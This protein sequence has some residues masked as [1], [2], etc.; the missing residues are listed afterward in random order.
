MNEIRITQLEKD[1]R[2]LQKRIRRACEILHKFSSFENTPDT[3]PVTRAINDACTML[4]SGR[5]CAEEDAAD[6]KGGGIV[7]Q[8]RGLQRDLIKC[9][10]ETRLWVSFHSSRSADLLEACKSVL[11]SLLLDGATLKEAVMLLEAAIAKAEGEEAT[12]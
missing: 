12:P 1:L 10:R 3:P 2:E 5:T 9:S 4:D 8:P 7:N 11:E 6:R